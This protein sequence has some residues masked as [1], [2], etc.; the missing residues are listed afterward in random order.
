MIFSN[1]GLTKH[2]EGCHSSEDCPPVS[3]I[4]SC[5]LCKREF[6]DSKYLKQHIGG[7][8]CK[9]RQAYL[10][11]T[12]SFSLN[13]SESPSSLLI[14]T[15]VS[16]QLI[17]QVIPNGHVSRLYAVSARKLARILKA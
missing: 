14:R 15:E 5:N 12:A 13:V 16:V 17:D 9:K 6:T 10:E 11:K 4:F 1:Y 8:K 7:Q 3:M 2:K